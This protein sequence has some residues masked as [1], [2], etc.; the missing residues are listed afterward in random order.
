MTQKTK[1]E[2][3]ENMQ[4]MLDSIK[5]L[6]AHKG[7]YYEKWKRNLRAA[8]EHTGPGGRGHGRED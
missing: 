7:P 8:L 4:R 5:Q 1:R 2:E 3:L 6:K